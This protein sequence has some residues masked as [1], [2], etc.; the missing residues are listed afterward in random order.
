MRIPI[1]LRLLLWLLNRSKSPQ[2]HELN[3]VEARLA[4]KKS[5]AKI[6]KFI[7]YPPVPIDQVI[8]MKVPVRDGEIPIRIYRPTKNIA[9]LI[10]YFHGGGFVMRSIDSHDKVC[11]RLARDNSAVVISVGYRLAPE[12]KFP[13]AV[14][15]CYDV[16]SWAS[17]NPN[18]HGGDPDRLI[19]MGDSA[20]GN[21]ATAVALM[22]RNLNG[23]KISL[24]ILIY[25]CTDATLSQPSIDAYG[26]GYFLTKKM[27]QWFLDHYKASDKDIYN[28]YLSMML[29]ENLTDL[30]QS[31]IC[32]AEYDPL[33]DEGKRYAD[34]LR[35]AG[36]KVIFKEYGGMIH[37]YFNMYKM[38]HQVSKT[39]N[40]IQIAILNALSEN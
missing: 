34:R 33:K 1:K 40:D 30:P 16:T 36:N 32:T 39:Y 38:S 12:F 10:V 2:I 28:P 3:P 26:N 13:T 11:R 5:I 9:P 29:A 18:V 27:M 4:A 6:E 22:S 20:G 31:F 19:V 7:D 35:E 17:N 25:P 24:Q 15:D 14:Y 21:L 37:G 23:P 8:D